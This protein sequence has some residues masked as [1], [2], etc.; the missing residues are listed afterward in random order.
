VHEPEALP[1]PVDQP[2][3]SRRRRYFIIG[4]LLLLGLGL[5]LPSLYCFFVADTDL[6]EA[7]AEADRMDP[8]G[9]R[10]LDLEAQRTAYPDDQN[11]GLLL[12]RLYPQIPPSWPYWDNPGRTSNDG[13]NSDEVL[14]LQQ[15]FS[16]LT[17]P[18]QL[19]AEQ[20]AALR[21]EIK[22]V[23]PVL[24]ELHKIDTMP[25]GRYPI[26]YTRDV[27]STS[28]TP[29][30]NTRA[31]AH[32]LGYDAMLRAQ[33]QDLPGALRSCR[34]IIYCNRAVGDEPTL[35]SGLIR[36]ALNAVARKK[37]ERMLAQGEPADTDLAAL[38]AVLQEESQTNLLL[39]GARGERAMGEGVMQAIQ[40]G[41]I[42]WS[43]VQGLVGGGPSPAL[44]RIEALLLMIPG[45]IKS[46]RAAVVR[47][48]NEF[49][50]FARL[51]TE[52]Q[53]PALKV[54]EEHVKAS[55][56]PILA[57]QL[58]P[59]IVKV[60]QAYHRHTAQLRSAIALVATE[61]YRRVNGKWPEKL[62]DLVPKY[63][64]KVPR[65]PYDGEPLRYRRLP[66]GVVVYSVSQDLTDNGGNLSDNQN[67]TGTDLGYRL[68]DV[69]KR[70]QP[71]KPRED[72][73]TSP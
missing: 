38:Q 55:H 5:A 71:W 42:M 60:S 59:A 27:L 23:A 62:T 40:R 33:D 13:R 44:S 54:M 6:R 21:S 36:I 61:R 47:F 48:E 28:L 17:P 69:N 45:S 65:D 10:L 22:R 53:V 43:Q 4:L 70:R 57:R 18:E 67:T 35:I 26:T 8:D 58:I 41:D 50:R 9:W 56:L 63:L 49:V 51:P 7:L 19:K 31:F 66:D 37:I 39:I 24:A 52:Q 3:R 12:I 1:V 20:L 14:Q 30:Q 11:S 15:S 2:P 34:E 25:G 32:L 73:T 29:S 64:E 46:N 16:D 68:W 72:I